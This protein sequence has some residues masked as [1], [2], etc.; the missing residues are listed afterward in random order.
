MF[1]KMI[2][3]LK[4]CDK[5]A[6]DTLFGV[7]KLLK[8]NCQEILQAFSAPDTNLKTFFFLISQFEFITCLITDIDRLSVI[9]L[10]L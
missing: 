2:H 8:T 3:D 7:S 9:F 10:W 1:Y 6:L 5:T 4:Q